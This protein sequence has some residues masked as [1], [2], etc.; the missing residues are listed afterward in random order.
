MTPEQ[1]QIYHTTYSAALA[2]LLGRCS[3]ANDA[4]KQASQFAKLSVGLYP[5]ESAEP[6]KRGPGRPPKEKSE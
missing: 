3:D 2:Q 6:A 5:T 1:H 4:V